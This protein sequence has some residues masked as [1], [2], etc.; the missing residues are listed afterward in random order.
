MEWRNFSTKYSLGGEEA[1]SKKL[2]LLRQG[3]YGLNSAM[4]M[5]V[6]P[7]LVSGPP[8]KSMARDDPP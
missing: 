8:P 4:K 7:A 5:S 3:L 2:A 6:E 1:F